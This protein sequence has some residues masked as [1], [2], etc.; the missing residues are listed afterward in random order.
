MGNDDKVEEIKVE[1][2]DGNALKHALDDAVRKIFTDD[3]KYIEKNTYVDVRLL[4][5]FLGVAV[6]GYALIYDFLNP[7]PASKWVLAFCVISYFIFMTILTGFMT[8]VEK[9]IILLATQKEASG[10][11]PDS[12]WTIQTSLKRFD[13]EFLIEMIKDDGATKKTITGSLTSSVANYVDVN[14][15][16]LVNKLKTDVLAQHKAMGNEKKNQ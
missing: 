9:N 12:T 3:L 6:A 14:G 4:L 2:W 13:D 1:K 8:F 7:F 11:D 15:V 5:S 16:I 10:L